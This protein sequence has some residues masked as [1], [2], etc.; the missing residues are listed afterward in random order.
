MHL[1]SS[2]YLTCICA[3][4][5]IHPVTNTQH[6]GNPW[7]P[8]R[9][10]GCWT[11]EERSWLDMLVHTN[12]SKEHQ[13][14]PDYREKQGD[15]AHECN[16]LGCYEDGDNCRLSGCEIELRVYAQVLTRYHG[17]CCKEEIYLPLR[18]REVRMCKM[19]DSR[20]SRCSKRYPRGS[21]ERQLPYPLID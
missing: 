13:C 18:C 1:A 14:H 11:R 3:S 17:R 2:W 10:A 6:P 12:R 7:T 16:F 4:K 20:Q 8:A 15:L 9:V 19:D 21:L 5:G